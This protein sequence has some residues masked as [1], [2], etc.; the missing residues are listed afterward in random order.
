[1]FVTARNTKDR[2]DDADG[3]RDGKVLSKI[4]LPAHIGEFLYILIG[5]LFNLPLQVFD[6]SRLKPIVR[7]LAILVMLGP[8]QMHQCP[9]LFQTEH[10]EHLVGDIRARCGLLCVE[11][12]VTSP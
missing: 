6:C 2:H 1:M 3:E 10:V 8:V 9:W 12:H 11:K 7:D 5:N 4:A